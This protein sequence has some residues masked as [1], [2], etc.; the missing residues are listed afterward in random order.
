M[1]NDIS[2][3]SGKKES[4]I[5]RREDKFSLRNKIHLATP[6]FPTEPRKVCKTQRVQNW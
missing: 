3:S 5:A 2:G 4:L 1:S 6:H